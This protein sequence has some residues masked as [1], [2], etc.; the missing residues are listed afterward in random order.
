MFRFSYFFVMLTALFSLSIG[1]VT[2][3]DEATP[4]WQAGSYDPY[5]F[6]YFTA[7]SDRYAAAKPPAGTVNRHGELEY[8][9][10]GV[11]G[12]HWYVQAT[13]PVWHFVT[14]GDPKNETVL[15]VHGYPGRPQDFRRMLSFFAD[16]RC[17]LPAM[18][19]LDLTPLQTRPQLGLAER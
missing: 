3:A 10:N 11:F 5:P 9:G 17:V 14:A 16:A 4:S 6:P 19:G 1:A 12:V 8:I 18:P 15:F 2:S 7:D 13:K